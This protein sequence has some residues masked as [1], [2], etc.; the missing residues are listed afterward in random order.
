MGAFRLEDG[1]RGPAGPKTTQPSP[2]PARRLGHVSRS[3][4]TAAP[5]S[6]DGGMS[7]STASGDRPSRSAASKASR[8]KGST[9][10]DERFVV[11]VGVSSGHRVT[12]WFGFQLPL[13]S[14]HHAIRPVLKIFKRFW[15]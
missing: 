3:Q 9:I 13:G 7:T 5:P 15:I 11:L 4:A 12:P 1:V 14:L 6:S 2:L 10:R 8:T